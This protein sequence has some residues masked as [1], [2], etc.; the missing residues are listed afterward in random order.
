MT[1]TPTPKMIKS[2]NN[3]II[4]L[5]IGFA[6]LFILVMAAIVLRL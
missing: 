3:W 1:G 2:D 4:G 5:A 6:V